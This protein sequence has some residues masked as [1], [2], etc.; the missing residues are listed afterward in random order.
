VDVKRGT[1]EYVGSPLDNYANALIT[2]KGEQGCSEQIGWGKSGVRPDAT[3]AAMI[4]ILAN[5]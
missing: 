1:C 4:G 2:R 3:F 5:T